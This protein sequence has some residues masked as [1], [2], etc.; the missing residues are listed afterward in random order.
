LTER[1]G[2]REKGLAMP[3]R[4]MLKGSAFNPEQISEVA[5]AFESVLADLNLVDRTDPITELIAKVIIDCAKRGEFDRVKLR[6]C[7]VT[8][9]T[10][11]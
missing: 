9:V 11:Q 7:A 10:K 6:D 8:A 1:R 3:I 5:A 2:Y 4:A